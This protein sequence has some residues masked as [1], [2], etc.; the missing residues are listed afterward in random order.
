LVLAERLQG[1]AQAHDIAPSP[2]REAKALDL[3]F[4]GRVVAVT[5][6]ATGFGRATAQAF[7]RRGA[8]VHVADLD[9]DGLAETTDIP[10]ISTTA[11]DLTNHGAVA[12]WIAEIEAERGTIDV[13]VNNAGG[14]L[15][16][17]FRP[18]EEADYE[19]WR[20]ILAVNL[21][22]AFLTIRAAAPAMKRAG[23]GRIV[24]ISSGAGL[25]A[26]RTGIQA[27]TSAKHAVIGLTR[28]MAQE[29]GPYGITVN[30][31]AP[32]LFPV[33]PGTWKQWNSYGSEKQQQVIRGLALRRLGEAE[34]IAKA[35]LF[36]ASGL[37]DYVTGQVLP[38]NGGSF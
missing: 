15:G 38:V 23:S 24:N 12:A 18:I 1:A 37:A 5:G 13:L 28:Q 3:E 35:V 29:L 7:A 16:R 30:A 11:L 31:I 8:H 21:D 27:Y 32:G 26:S 36:F 34:D 19:D 33:S 17:E 6:A 25:R 2:P 22:A 20:A 14:V 10:G 4:T 9:N